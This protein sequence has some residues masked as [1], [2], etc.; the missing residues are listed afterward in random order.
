MYYDKEPL[1]G[2]CKDRNTVSEL[3]AP[4]QKCSLAAV[5]DYYRKRQ[6]VKM[7]RTTGD[8]QLNAS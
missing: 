4:L 1:Q 2:K 8:E 5:G 7:P 6:L 3:L